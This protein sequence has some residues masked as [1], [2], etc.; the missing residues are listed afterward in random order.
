[1]FDAFCPSNLCLEL[2]LEEK[3]QTEQN[4]GNSWTTVKEQTCY[5]QLQKSSHFVEAHSDRTTY[6]WI[7]HLSTGFP[8]HQVWSFLPDLLGHLFGSFIFHTLN[9]NFFT[10]YS[11]QMINYTGFDVCKMRKLVAFVLRYHMK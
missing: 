8:L 11:F 7:V 9:K 3:R 10:H 5:K 1:M 6:Q 2:S 4:T